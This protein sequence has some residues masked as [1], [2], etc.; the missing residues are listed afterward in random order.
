MRNRRAVALVVLWTAL[1]AAAGFAD[2]SGSEAG[3]ATFRK[4]LAHELAYGRY[5][6]SID[7]RRTSSRER[8]FMASTDI[9]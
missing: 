9:E 1:P 8:I 4:R 7:M 5:N 3:N 6:P 2:E